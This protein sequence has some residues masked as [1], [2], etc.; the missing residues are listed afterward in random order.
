MLLKDLEK[1][2]LNKFEL[3]KLAFVNEYYSN[4]GT[5]VNSFRILRLFNKEEL[6]KGRDLYELNEEEIKELIT[7]LPS[8]SKRTIQSLSCVFDKYHN[9]AIEKGLNVTNIN[10]MNNINVTEDLLIGL[11]KKTLKKKFL[12]KSEMYESIDEYLKNETSVYQCASIVPLLF[13]GIAG[14]GFCEIRNLKPEDVNFDTNIITIK[15]SESTREVWVDDKC[16]ALIEEACNETYRLRADG[17]I[18]NYNPSDYI[19]KNSK[20]GNTDPIKRQRVFERVKEVLGGVVT[21]MS[22][23]KS[24]QMEM[25]KRMLKEKGTLTNDDYKLVTKLYNKEESSWLRLKEDFLIIEN[26]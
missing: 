12:T 17:K 6:A 24:G 14:E 11:Q 9:W 4:E 1:K 5:Q 15:G 22:L 13:H 8:T 3:N 10:P 19:F 16:L 2:E 21:P 7:S 26:K 18:D 25:L 20:L 23:L